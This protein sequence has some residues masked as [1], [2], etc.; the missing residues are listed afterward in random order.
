[1]S[2]QQLYYTSC[3]HGLSGYAGYQFN[4]VTDGT[5]GETMRSVES[6]TA[7]EPPRS[8]AYPGTPEELSLCPVNLCFAPGKTT[9]LANVS[10]VG[11]D[12]SQRFGNYFAHALATG[13][14]DADDADLLPIELWRAAWWN[15]RPVAGTSL[16]P[17]EGPLPA[18]PLSR[19]QVARFLAAHPHR[20]RLAAL[21]SAAELAQRRADRSVLVVAESA[22][23]VAAWFAAVSYLLPPRWVRRLSFSTYGSRPSRS[24]LHLLGTLPEAKLDLGPDAEEKFYLFDFPGERF[25]KLGVH[26]LA[27]LCVSIGLLELPALWGW[28]DSL[29][30]GDET[31]LGDWYPVVA[32][33]AALGRVAITE[34]D[35]DVVI[36]WLHAGDGLPTATQ[37]AIARAVH[38]HSNV[39]VGHRRA[40]L[41]VSGRTGD[42]GLWE[43]V[44]YELLEPLLLLRTD[45]STV[46]NELLPSAA[47]TEFAAALARVGH[48][49]TAKAE[50][51]LRLAEDPADAL[52]LLDWS[53]HAG[54]PIDPD[55]P[56][57]CGRTMVAPLLAADR[58]LP[59]PQR[60]QVTRVVEHWPT[61]REGI[62]YYLTALADREPASMAAMMAGMTGEL[63]AERDIPEGSP[64]QVP[65]LVQRALRRKERPAEILASL[66]RRGVVKEADDLLLSMLWPNRTWRVTDAA[67]VLAVLDP[68]V[69]T[70]VLG[71][72]EAALAR[73]PSAT[74]AGLGT[75]ARLCDDLMASPLAGLLAAPERPILR[76]VADLHRARSGARRIRDLLPVMG[77]LRDRVSVSALV[78]SWAWL[79]PMVATLPADTP[80]DLVTALTWMNAPEVRRYLELIRGRFRAPDA[81]SPVHAAALWLIARTEPA[82]LHDQQI[83]ELLGLAAK[84]WQPEPLAETVSLVQAVDPDSARELGD[85]IAK[86]G[87]ARQPRTVAALRGTTRLLGHAGRMLGRAAKGPRP[88]GADSGTTPPER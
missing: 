65:Y 66:A 50:E 44:L 1:M 34:A 79:A 87:P 61:V 15:R 8:T 88:E 7:Y 80:G 81:G 11:R 36:G 21:L 59:Q 26:P 25:P 48:Q 85:L 13:D 43:Q 40:L 68:Q 73:K 18:G 58:H 39:T 71:W 75:Y 83:T 55:V 14:L 37:N 49:L 64:V 86:R 20:G 29:A 27:S 54:L 38:G 3:E 72:F 70:G 84:F 30:R 4:A 45:G 77:A 24:R 9:I 82:R 31:T 56:A 74:P 35:L 63:L 67:E 76:E 52:D 10:Y 60:D 6:L 22:D 2:F 5:S 78:L 46:A 42:T 33:A 57:E 32:A 12:S 23:E 17:L 69:L 28:T 51:Q 47:A 41:A 53:W 16:P 62:V 19:E